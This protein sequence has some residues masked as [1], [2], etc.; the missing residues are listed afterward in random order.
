MNKEFG[1]LGQAALILGLFNLCSQI[2]GLFRDRSIAS[3]IGPS[4]LLDAY[5]AAFRIPD[6]IFVSVSS[7]VSITIIIPFILEKMKDGKVSEEACDFI[8]QLFT[9]F[10]F[11]III[12]S[13]IVFIFLP[14]IVHFSTPGFDS[15][16]QHQVVML[17][18]IM[19]LSPI[20]LGLSNLFG[21]ITQLFHR[22]FIYSLSPI[23]YNIGIIIGVIFLYPHFG[24]S[25]MAFGVVLGALMHFLI[26][27]FSSRKLGF[28]PH[29]TRRIDF[30]NIVKVLEISVPRTLGLSANS[31]A[32][33]AIVSFASFL[34]AGSISI[35]TF[36]NNLQTIPQ[37]IVGTSYAVAAFPLLAQAFA[38]KS[39]EEFKKHLT[40]AGRAIIFWTV[41][42]TFLFI[43]LR[44]QI[45]RV[46]LG[47]NTFSWENTRLVAAGLALFS[48]SIMAQSMISLFSR[49]YYASGN[50]KRPLYI[51]IA[52]SVLIVIFS[53]EL[54]HFFENTPMFRYFIES[55][56]RVSDIKG[57]AVLMLPLA[58]SL[59]TILNFI[60][61]WVSVRKHFMKGEPFI[62][63]TFFQML[64]ASFFLAIT[65]YGVLFVFSPLFGTTTFWGVL[66]A[67]FIAGV[68]GILVGGIVLHLLKNEELK[69]FMASIK[70]KFW[71]AERIAP[72]Q[73]EL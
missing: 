52:C 61:H 12:I 7:L 51:N 40:K 42:I 33:I 68:F 66:G 27:A 39:K 72:P 44:A 54:I 48:L 65:V 32:L 43:V 34:G 47:T 15:G 73:E 19:L 49:A 35:F 62:A 6:F 70:T 2:L 69:E 50:T 59:G 53:Y 71:R 41:P 67:G 37:G 5:Y 57:T 3:V 22:F 11:L 23:V 60:L 24:I 45:V 4:P 1:N 14:N 9:V 8:S 31:M 13:G 29:F 64:G 21:S 18:R 20:L 55:L 10:L 46:V 30:K 25:G 58:Y 16:L 63:K 17:S 28:S 36:A 38:R 26:Q 56:L